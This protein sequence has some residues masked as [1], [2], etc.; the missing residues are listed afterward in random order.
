MLSQ[1]RFDVPIASGLTHESSSLVEGTLVYRNLMPFVRILTRKMDAV[2]ES[3][4]LSPCRALLLAPVVDRGL[5]WFTE[6]GKFRSKA[7]ASP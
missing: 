4:F 7:Q 2:C 5:D 1:S 3:L 6:K